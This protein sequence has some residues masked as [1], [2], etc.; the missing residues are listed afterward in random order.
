MIKPTRNR[1][2][3]G[4]YIGMCVTALLVGGGIWINSMSQSPASLV[5]LVSMQPNHSVTQASSASLPKQKTARSEMLKKSAPAKAELI[6]E[7]LFKSVAEE[8]GLPLF[9]LDEVYDINDSVPV[10]GTLVGGVIK[11]GDITE[12]NEQSA[13]G[14]SFQFPEM[15]QNDSGDWVMVIG[16]Q[17]I[18]NRSMH[19]EVLSGNGD[20]GRAGDTIHF[21]Y[22]MFS[23]ATGELVESS[24]DT[25]E[26][27]LAITLGDLG[28][29][30]EI[31]NYLHNAL[32][33]K[34]EGTKMQVI[35]EQ[36]L[37]GLP[38]QRNPHDGY[39][40]VVEIDRVVP[41]TEEDG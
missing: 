13:T 14:D 37:E 39:V 1:S 25:F 11:Q 24:K 10:T 31:P 5:D 34:T 7:D 8:E 2:H 32:L 23:W 40:L 29:G 33:N 20:M 21:R 17:P 18:P 15:V 35:Y 6:E 9:E 41:R 4:L 19:R 22:D 28:N 3:K 30:A 26:E 38:P 12:A 16:N 27:S 36:S